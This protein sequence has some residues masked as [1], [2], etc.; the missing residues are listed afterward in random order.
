VACLV[1]AITGILSIYKPKTE[2]SF[3]ADTGE[4]VAKTEGDVETQPS[5]A[6]RVVHARFSPA[7]QS[8][9][10]HA[11]RLS[12]IS[13]Q[14][15]EA[16]TSASSGHLFMGRREL[17]PMRPASK[18]P[19]TEEDPPSHQHGGSKKGKPLSLSVKAKA[20]PSISGPR[21]QALKPSTEKNRAHASAPIGRDSR[22]PTSNFPSARTK[23][24]PKFNSHRKG[25]SGSTVPRSSSSC[26]IKTISKEKGKCVEGRDAVST[27]RS[28]P[29]QS[30]V[31]G[32]SRVQFDED[33]V[34]EKKL[35]PFERSGP[36]RAALVS[37]LEKTVRD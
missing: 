14:K 30:R 11:L 19:A 27:G 32:T 18:R 9:N 34:G 25:P 1:N 5:P 12:D 10:G 21:T 3:T 20:S 2:N 35:I 36:S 33:K 29:P 26:G 8:G 13:P 7:A 22:W 4:V 24:K 28:L 37:S 31:S 15:R 6:V 16:E 23:Y 17:S